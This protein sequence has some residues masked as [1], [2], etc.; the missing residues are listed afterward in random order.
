MIWVLKEIGWGS[1]H[2]NEIIRIQIFL[3]TTCQIDMNFALL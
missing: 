2:Y 3:S 1:L